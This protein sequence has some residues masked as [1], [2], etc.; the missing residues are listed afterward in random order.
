MPIQTSSV[1]AANVL[2][3]RDATGA[4]VFVTIETQPTDGPHETTTH[5]EI[6]QAI[7]RVSFTGEIIEK[8]KRDATSGGQI[9]DSL[10][11]ITTFTP[12]WNKEKVELLAAMWESDHL[13][14]MRAGCAHQSPVWREGRYGREIDLNNT[15][16]CPV[17][18]YRFGR[19]WLVSPP[20]ETERTIAALRVL[21]GKE[22]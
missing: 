3:G 8:G 12:G 18:G 15:P 10:H 13:N 22:V 21:F 19:K 9:V 2:L 7:T 6:Q 1:I 17:T 20:E 14:D 5:E 16:A 4:R 11:D